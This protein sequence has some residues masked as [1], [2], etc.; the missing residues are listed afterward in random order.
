MLNPECSPDESLLIGLAFSAFAQRCSS[1]KANFEQLDLCIEKFELR[2]TLCRRFIAGDYISFRK[3][4]RLRNIVRDHKRRIIFAV[5]ELGS[6]QATVIALSQMGVRVATPFWGISPPYQQVAEKCNTVLIDLRLPSAVKGLIR[7]FVYLQHLGISPLLV[8]EA[9]GVS[10]GTYQFL[11]YN[12]NCSRFLAALAV[13]I[14]CDIALLWNRSRSPTEVDIGVECFRC[15][16][17][18]LT[19]SLLVSI[20]REI[21]AEPSQYAWDNA[22]IIFTDPSASRV[23]LLEMPWILSWREERLSRV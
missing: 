10:C 17:P 1:V 9:P 13:Y 12:V 16:T 20:E 2:R 22:G 19:Q 18:D 6:I 11:G 8:L 5:S 15:Q 4:E 21:A 3:T 14:D 23:A 7:Q